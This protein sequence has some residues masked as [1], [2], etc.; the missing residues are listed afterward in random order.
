MVKNPICVIVTIVF[1]LLVSMSIGSWCVGIFL[2][3]FS[4]YQVM[5]R[6]KNHQ[7]NGKEWVSEKEPKRK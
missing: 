3:P 2:G 1:T 5:F 6:D 7:W 4:M